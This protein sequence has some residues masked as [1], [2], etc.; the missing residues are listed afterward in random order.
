MSEHNVD[1]VIRARD[2]ASAKIGLFADNMTAMQAKIA[3]AIGG[4]NLKYDTVDKLKSQFEQRFELEDRLYSATHTGQQTA[5]KNTD[6]YFAGLKIK[7]QTNQS[8]LTLIDRT[9]AA[10]RK[11]ILSDYAEFSKSSVKELIRSFVGKGTIAGIA[12]FA[13][14]RIIDSITDAHKRLR[15]S[16]KTATDYIN[17]WAESIPLFGRVS[18]SIRELATELSGVNE[19][20]K[21][22]ETV[23]SYVSSAFNIGESLAQIGRAHV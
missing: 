23:K 3:K 17:V 15:E 2:E 4:A 18:R 7:W 19:A 21:N 9:E 22:L 8:M 13:V 10:E 5:L 6:E 16:E 11:R 20:A 1:L 12:A 14:T